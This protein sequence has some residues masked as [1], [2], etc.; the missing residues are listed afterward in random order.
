MTV[1]ERVAAAVGA[2]LNKFFD[3][4]ALQYFIPVQN[5]SLKVDAA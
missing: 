5:S 4:A 1:V 3:I 2:L